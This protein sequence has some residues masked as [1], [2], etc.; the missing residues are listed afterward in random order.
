[1]GVRAMRDPACVAEIVR[2]SDVE[3]EA[4]QWLWPGRIP[5]GKLSLLEGHPGIGKSH[6]TLDFAA[7]VTIGRAFPGDDDAFDRANVVI[8]T[9]ED[10]LGD[11]VR[12]RLQAAGGNP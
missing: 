7:R 2:L 10:G 12:P 1:M 6:L 5:L 9:A 3:P 11:T 8:L 4:V